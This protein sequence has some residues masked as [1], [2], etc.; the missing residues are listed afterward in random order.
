M[1]AQFPWIV[2]A[3]CTP[4]FFIVLRLIDITNVLRSDIS[5]AKIWADG[6]YPHAIAEIEKNPEWRLVVNAYYSDIDRINREVT[7]Y[8]I[9]NIVILVGVLMVSLAMDRGLIDGELEV[10][11]Q[12][13][14]CLLGVVWLF[15]VV[16]KFSEA[17]RFMS[18]VEVTINGL[19]RD[20]DETEK[21]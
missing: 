21:S 18:N 3:F 12:V 7:R 15:F 10:Y 20:K 13:S 8:L 6:A 14:Y 16:T 19:R 17:R 5:E 1:L 11:V 4:C 2:G 9:T